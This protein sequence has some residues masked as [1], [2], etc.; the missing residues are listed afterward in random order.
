MPLHVGGH[1]LANR[2]FLAPLSGIS[3]V[4]FRRLARRFGAGMVVS[5]MVASGEF[6]KGCN[7]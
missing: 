6:V 4:P 7:E 2:V 1:R 5:E 3:D